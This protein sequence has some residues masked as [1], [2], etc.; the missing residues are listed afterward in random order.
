[1]QTTG[2]HGQTARTSVRLTFF[3]NCAKMFTELE[4]V[5]QWPLTKEWF[6]V[7]VQL[8][9][10]WKVQLH[11]LPISANCV[12]VKYRC[13]SISFC[14]NAVRITGHASINNS[15]TCLDK[16]RCK[17]VPTNV[18]SASTPCGWGMFVSSYHLK[19]MA[20]PKVGRVLNGKV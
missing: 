15:Q 17:I 2:I 8:Q 3:L 6:S 11:L 10:W 1:M 9:C 12:T 16:A 14:R 5:N 19:V 4:W 13:H 7:L 20:Y 18:Q